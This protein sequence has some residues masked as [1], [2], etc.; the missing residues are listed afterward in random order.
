MR[1]TFAGIPKEKITI[2]EEKQEL[3]ELVKPQGDLVAI[4]HELYSEDVAQKI[5]AKLRERFEADSVS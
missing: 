1:L 2:R 4:L 3:A 5:A